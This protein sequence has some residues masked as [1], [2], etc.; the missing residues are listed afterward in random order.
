MMIALL[1]C[2]LSYLL[3]S[4]KFNLLFQSSGY[5][6]E[7]EVSDHLKKFLRVKVAF[8]LI[9]FIALLSTHESPLLFKLFLLIWFIL[10]AFTIISL[11]RSK[12]S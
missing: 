1:N 7:G 10:M 4:L 12:T 8:M 5:V 3:R 9:I 6:R 2:S 11:L